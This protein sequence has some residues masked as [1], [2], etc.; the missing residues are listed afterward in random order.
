M[1][2]SYP[3]L[4]AHGVEDAG[5]FDQFDLFAGSGPWNTTQMQAADGQAIRQFEILALV[6][7]KLVPFDPAAT[8]PAQ[9]AFA[10]AAQPVDAATPGARVP[11]FISGGFNHEAL[12]WNAATDTLP[13]RQAVFAGS[14]IY[15]QQLL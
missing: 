6:G 15:V 12:V 9:T 4:L 11:I 2:A 14:P 8:T 10:I 3:D 13:E 5:R 1:A 7:N